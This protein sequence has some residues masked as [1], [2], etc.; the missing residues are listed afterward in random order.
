VLFFCRAGTC[1]R[2]PR[3]LGRAWRPRAATR[4]RHRTKISTCIFAVFRGRRCAHV[5]GR[6]P[7]PRMKTADVVE[8]GGS[9]GPSPHGCVVTAAAAREKTR[10]SGLRRP[11]VLRVLGIRNI[12]GRVGGPVTFPAPLPVG[13]VRRVFVGPVGLLVTD[14]RPLVG[15]G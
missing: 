4:C 14:G 13:S 11:C 15:L 1:P 2:L 9:P 6:A 10:M 7:A 3:P 8:W 5:R 12:T